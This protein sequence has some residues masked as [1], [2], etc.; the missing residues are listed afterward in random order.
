[1]A[2]WSLHAVTRVP[3]VHPFVGFERAAD[4]SKLAPLTEKDAW[5]S[6]E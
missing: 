3:I 1:A 5:K 6:L 2:M 4:L